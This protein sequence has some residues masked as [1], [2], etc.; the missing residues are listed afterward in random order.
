MELM[1]VIEGAAKRLFEGCNGECPD[2]LVKLMRGPHIPDNAMP[3]RAP[4][5]LWF[6]AVPSKKET[7]Q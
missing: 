2:S 6:W 5:G 7:I 3:Y 1:Y 4:N